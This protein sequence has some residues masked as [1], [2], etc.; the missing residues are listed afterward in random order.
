M[1]YYKTRIEERFILWISL[2]PVRTN[3]Q[4]PNGMYNITTFYLEV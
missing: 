4:T 1:A 2:T 3:K